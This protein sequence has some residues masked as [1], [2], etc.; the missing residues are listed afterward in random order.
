MW[1]ADHEMRDRDDEFVGVGDGSVA[2]LDVGHV[3]ALSQRIAS[4]SGVDAQRRV[5]DFAVPDQYFG[6]ALRLVDRDGVA[7][8]TT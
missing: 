8:G 4:R 3:R 2:D 7:D 5:V 1:D 6:D